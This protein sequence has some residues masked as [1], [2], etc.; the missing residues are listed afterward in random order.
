MKTVAKMNSL[1]SDRV[2][3]EPETLELH[4]KHHQMNQ[5]SPAPEGKG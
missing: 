4:R 3:K 2:S 1:K 5:L